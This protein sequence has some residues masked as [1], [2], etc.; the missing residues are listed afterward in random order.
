IEMRQILI[1]CDPY[2]AEMEN[3][4]ELLEPKC[5]VKRTFIGTSPTPV[6]AQ[7]A[8]MLSQPTS[9]LIDRCHCLTEKEDDGLPGKLGLFEQNG[10]KV[11]KIFHLQQMIPVLLGFYL[12]VTSTWP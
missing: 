4:C 8:L 1:Y 6:T 5:R 2:I 9:Q 12:S 11:H 3:C 10:E 7:S